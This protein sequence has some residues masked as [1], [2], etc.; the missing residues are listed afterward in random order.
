[1]E[2][3]EAKDTKPDAAAVA[4]PV[5]ACMPPEIPLEVEPVNRFKEPEVP[6]ELAAA[7]LM[8]RLPELD[9]TPLPLEIHT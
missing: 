3:P 7:E 2:P 9:D 6:A 5:N 1:M 8:L 4:A